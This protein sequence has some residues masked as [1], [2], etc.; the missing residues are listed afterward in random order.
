MK[1]R[2][3]SIACVIAMLLSALLCSAS[4]VETGDTQMSTF[5]GGRMKCRIVDIG[6]GNERIVSL[7]I[8]MRATVDDEQ[9]ILNA[10]VKSTSERSVL[11]YDPDTTGAFP[12]SKGYGMNVYS[13]TTNNLGGGELEGDMRIIYCDFVNHNAPYGTRVSVTMRNNTQGGSAAATVTLKVEDAV[14]FVA[15]STDGFPMSSG[16]RISVTGTTTTSFYSSVYVSS[17]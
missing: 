12:I 1:K 16:D 9:A 4:A 10:V 17:T 5:A 7:T 8:P 13:G 11:R 14:V 15:K 6:T 2:L 3:M